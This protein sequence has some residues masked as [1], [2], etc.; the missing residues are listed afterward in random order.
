MQEEID[1]LL[2]HDARSSRY[3]SDDLGYHADNIDLSEILMRVVEVRLRRGGRMK[4]KK[5]NDFVETFKI[6]VEAF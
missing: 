1:A 6:L 5:R 3:V 2:S 4:G